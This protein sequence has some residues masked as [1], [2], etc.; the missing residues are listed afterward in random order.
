MAEDA[1]KEIVNYVSKATDLVTD[2]IKQRMSHPLI[3]SFIL[4]WVVF[5]WE[6]I[7]YII[8]ANASIESK[9][10]YVN[11]CFYTST[12]DKWRLYFLQPLGIA[13][14]YYGALAWV[15]RGLDAINIKTIKAKIAHD[16]EVRASKFKEEI[17]VITAQRTLEIE[18]AEKKPI[19]ELNHK[20]SLAT[21]EIENKDNLISILQNE[22]LSLQE[23]I[24]QT[25]QSLNFQRD[26]FTEY[27]SDTNL[28]LDNQGTRLHHNERALSA[29]INSMESRLSNGELK[30]MIQDLKQNV[31]G[32]EDFLSIAGKI[33]EIDNLNPTYHHTFYP[34][35][36][37]TV[38]PK[39]RE[40]LKRIDD[41]IDFITQPDLNGNV[42][43]V[44]VNN[45]NLDL[46]PQI[47]EV[48]K[49]LI[50]YGRNS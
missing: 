45:Y 31:P 48:F 37:T 23:E 1:Q 41:S 11:S 3:G 42:E 9:I 49:K 50:N 40:E 32:W 20:L 33:R 16:A 35:V 26:R 7:L 8:F 38:L 15:D 24:N 29:L 5:N 25:Q 19:E 36:K 30:N 17:L 43:S 27:Q 34:A 12:W 47:I 44:I 2:P 28:T 6:P 13:L 18:K 4:A 39:L 22:R 10:T 46:E 14:F 21:A